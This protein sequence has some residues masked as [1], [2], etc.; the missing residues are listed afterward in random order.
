MPGFARADL[1]RALFGDRTLVR[2]SALRGSGFLLPVD[3][4]DA[5]CSASDR[6]WWY[7]AEAD[8]VLGEKRRH[9]MTDQ[10]TAVL[11]GRTLTTRR[12]RSEL[13]VGAEEAPGLRHLLKAL[14][15]ERVIVA[16]EG[17]SGWR[18]NQYGYALWD[19]WL[20]DHPARALDPVESRVAVAA[21]YLEGH[22]PGTVADFAW[23]S[24][25][26][27][28]NARDALLAAAGPSDGDQYDIAA[29]EPTP[30]A[31]GL[32]LLPVWDTALV[33][34]RERRR[35]VEPEHHRFVYDASGNVTS[36]IA[37]RGKVIGVWDRGG[38]ADRIE[39]AAA[40]FA[41]EG[42]RDEVAGEADLIAA[43][44]GASRVELTFTTNFVDL[45]AATRNRFLSPLSGG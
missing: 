14:A 21:W 25:L 28:V 44:V 4:V 13:G 16:A 33:S 27:P 40:F 35:M 32:R 37:Y 17:A 26:K 41:G 31:E 3:R 38:D 36:T 39:I 30:D 11:D 22:G 29:P 18:S 15:L 24:G 12:I 1:D 8:R 42:P 20:P 43:A 45:T 9:H 2:M 23:W 10:V 6:E 19:Q 7:L 5:V 34:Q